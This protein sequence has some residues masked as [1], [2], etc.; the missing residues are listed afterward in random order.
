MSEQAVILSP[1]R[2]KREDA[3]DLQSR[4]YRELGLEA[5]ASEL[6]GPGEGAQATVVELIEPVKCAA[7]LLEDRAA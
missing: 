3:R 1:A 4:L 5:V 6:F 2:P 7:S